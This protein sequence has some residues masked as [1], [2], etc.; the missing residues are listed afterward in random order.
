MFNPD[1]NAKTAAAKPIDNRRWYEVLT[2]THTHANKPLAKGG[3][4]KLST[5]RAAR[6]PDVF[7]ETS[8]PADVAAEVEY[9]APPVK[10]A[11]APK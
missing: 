5:E 10:P 6:F 8:A 2:D 7:K 4:I 1:D 9:I 11:N 3:K